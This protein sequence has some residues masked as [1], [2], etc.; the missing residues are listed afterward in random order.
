VRCPY[1]FDAIRSDEYGLGPFGGSD[2]E[3]TIAGDTVVG[4]ADHLDVASNGFSRLV[5]EPF[6]EWIAVNHSDDGP[7]MYADWPGTSTEQVDEQSIQLWEQHSRQYVDAD[8]VGF[9]G[10]A[11]QDAVASDPLSGQVVRT[12]AWCDGAPIADSGLALCDGEVRVYD[13]GRVIWYYRGN[14]REGAGPQATGW[15]EQR[16]TPRAWRRCRSS[17]SRAM[18]GIWRSV[19]GTSRRGRRAPGRTTRSS[20]SSRASTRSASSG[21]KGRSKAS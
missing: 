2:L 11:P 9:V 17:P 6:A 5:W 19:S 7:L 8:R 21:C 18:R 13:D 12:F 3:L 10:V 4:L 14:M 1:D 16:L 15:L 20:R